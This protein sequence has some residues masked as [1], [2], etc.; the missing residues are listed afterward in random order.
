M[1]VT[2]T[3][4]TA[5]PAGTTLGD[6]PSTTISVGFR[7]PN[8]KSLVTALWEDICTNVLSDDDSFYT[9]LG[10]LAAAPASP[11]LVSPQARGSMAREIVHKVCCGK[12]G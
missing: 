4:V 10:D 1:C 8:Y 3:T 9:D 11:G 5:V 12:G 6:G 2:V 7:A